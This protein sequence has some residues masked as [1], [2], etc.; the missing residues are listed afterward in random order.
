M[1][2]SKE[3]GPTIMLQVTNILD[4]GLKIKRMEKE[5]YNIRMEQFMMVSGSMISLKIRGK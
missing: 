5:F 1:D 3:K 2:K 4:N